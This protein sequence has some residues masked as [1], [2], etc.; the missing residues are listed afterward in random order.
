MTWMTGYMGLILAVQLPGCVLIFQMALA[1][2]TVGLNWTY[3][4]KRSDRGQTGT[5]WPTSIGRARTFAWPGQ[6]EAGPGGNSAGRKCWRP[7]W[8]VS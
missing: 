6:Q 8:P 2:R 5:P 1:S 3:Q 7:A 4:A